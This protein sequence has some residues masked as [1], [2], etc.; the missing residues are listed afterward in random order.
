MYIDVDT[1][2]LRRTQSS[3]A[4]DTLPCTATETETHNEIQELRDCVGALQQELELEEEAH[5]IWRESVLAE[6]ELAEKQRDA[7]RAELKG[8]RDCVEL[9]ERG[10]EHLE[11]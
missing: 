2:A 10:L 9:Y 3:R 4:T 6:L 11:E 8:W 5:K 7:A 1:T